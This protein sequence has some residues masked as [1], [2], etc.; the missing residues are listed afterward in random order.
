MEAGRADAAIQGE[1]VVAQGR[2]AAGTCERE[3]HSGMSVAGGATGLPDELNIGCDRER[4][5][6]RGWPCVLGLS[7]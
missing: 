6:S 4:E 3:S 1:V 5:R 2:A 7:I